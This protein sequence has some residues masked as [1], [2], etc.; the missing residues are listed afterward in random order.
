MERTRQ[1][2]I[3]LGV[4]EQIDFPGGVPKADVPEWM[5][6]HDIFIN[7]TNRDNTPVSVMEAM[8]SGLNVVS[9]NVDGL[10][11]LVDHGRDGLLVAPDDAEGMAEAVRRLLREPA[12]ASS[13]AEQAR[14]KVGAFDW[15][16]VMPQWEAIYNELMTP[17]RVARP[18]QAC[19]VPKA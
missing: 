11:Y 8:A 17:A 7:T 14:Q 5:D 9:T 15:S 2:A 1:L 13:L 4:Q 6:R 16:E 10:P 12:W 19:S 18:V 3:Q